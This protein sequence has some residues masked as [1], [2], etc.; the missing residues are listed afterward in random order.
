MLLMAIRLLCNTSGSGKTRLLFEGL[1]RYWGFYFV[2]QP[3]SDGLGAH[4][5]ESLIAGMQRAPGWTHDIFKH[6][7]P[8]QARLQNEDIAENLICKALLARWVVFD[9]FIKVVKELNGGVVPDGAQRDWLLFQI[10]PAI[11]V[12]DMDPFLAFIS[13]CLDDVSTAELIAL[14]RKFTVSKVLGPA[15][16]PQP[17]FFYVLDEVQAAG[18][19]HIN[20]FA[21]G[22]GTTP[23]PVLCPIVRNLS[24]YPNRSVK[25]IVSGTGFSLALFERLLSSNVAKGEPEWGRVHAMGD[26]SDRDTQSACISRYLP[27]SFLRSESGTFLMTRMHEWLRGRYAALIKSRW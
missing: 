26:F 14:G 9:T 22:L 3:G 10:L 21:D 1:C 8:K 6:S 23:R 15:F 13:S 18:T 12:N 19:E 4:D 27:P 25:M 20:A 2:A 11:Q 7:D 17:H 5:L 16:S 24:S